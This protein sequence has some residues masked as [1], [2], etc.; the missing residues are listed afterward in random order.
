VKICPQ[1]AAAHPDSIAHC[2]HDGAELRAQIDAWV[3]RT[4]GG[5]YRVISR[6]GRGGMSS[7]YLAQE[8]SEDDLVAV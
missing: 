5:R 8:S 4:I 6:L 2:P 3:G 7:V 1:C